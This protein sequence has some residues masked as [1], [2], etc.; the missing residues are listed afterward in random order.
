MGPYPGYTLWTAEKAA[1]SDPGFIFT[2]SPAPEPAPKLSTM[3]P[4]IP[5]LFMQAPGPRM[6]EAAE[7]IE[8]ILNEK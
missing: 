6:A 2:I 1:I 8:S 7:L 5:G 3:L 4:M